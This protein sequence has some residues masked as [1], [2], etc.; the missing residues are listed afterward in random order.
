MAE[1]RA[2]KIWALAGATIHIPRSLLMLGA[3]PTVVKVPTP[4]FLIE[5]PK[6]LV[7]FDTGCN[8]KILDDPVA[9]WGPMAAAMPFDWNKNETLDKQI[10]RVGYKTSD[11]KYVVLSHGHLDHAGGLTYFPQATFIAGAGELR[12]SYWPDP[13]RRWAFILE[14]FVPTRG[15]RWTEFGH[16]QDLFGDGAVTFLYTPGHTPGECSILVNLP[17]RRVLIT[18]D[19]VH[20]RASLD[21][22][23]SMPLS[24]NHGQA[25]ASLKRIK[26]IRDIGGAQIWITHDPD[27]W[28]EC[29]HQLD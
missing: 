3:E 21:N 19:T 10:E 27:D 23:V 1:G 12:Y 2:R 14:D 13:D 28:K 18:G 5:H 20:T 24:V 26:A 17:N 4:S 16:D 6:G 29:P 22:E 25:M 8:P 9:Y 7:L 15:Y 11:I